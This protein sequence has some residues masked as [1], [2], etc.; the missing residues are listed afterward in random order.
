MGYNYDMAV[1]GGFA[2]SAYPAF[3][4]N[5]A[6]EE[7]V[8][9]M[10]HED[11]GTALFKVNAETNH[12]AFGFRPDVSEIS[13]FMVYLTGSGEVQYT[14]T[15]QPGNPEAAI[16]SGSGT[17]TE[18]GWQE[19]DLEKPVSVT[20]GETYYMELATTSGEVIAYGSAC[21]GGG[22][23]SYNYDSGNWFSTPYSVAF[24]MYADTTLKDKM[25]ASEL[26]QR[27]CAGYAEGRAS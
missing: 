4:V 1:L 26:T 17:V 22:V 27:R 9:F 2:E 16:M 13:R 14:L 7:I 6:Q 11:S 12:C 10:A 3:R 23:P 24:R 19:F 18:N 8:P 25:Y 21:P 20:P 15:T 5:D